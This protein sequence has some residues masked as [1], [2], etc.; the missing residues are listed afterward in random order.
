MS[1]HSKDE[2]E[3]M[4]EDVVNELCLSGKM[5]AKHGPLGTPPAKLVRLVLDQKDLIIRLLNAGFVDATPKQK[6]KVVCLCG[7][8]SF[9]DRHAISRWELEQQ[10]HIVLMINYLPSWYAHSQGWEGSDHFGEQAGLKKHLDEL[11]FRKIDLADEVLVIN[12]GGYIGENTRK[13]IEYAESTG[14]PVE[15]LEPQEGEDDG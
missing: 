8:T 7:S 6:P 9:A 12:I 1:C 11:H 13:E 2:L 14:K 4:L 5:I 3:Q 10:G 15:Y